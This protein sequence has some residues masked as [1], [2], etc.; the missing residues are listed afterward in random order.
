MIFDEVR[1]DGREKHG[2]DSGTSNG[3]S[4][5]KR[6]APKRHEVV[7]KE[8]ENSL[9]KIHCHN[10][11]GGAIHQSEANSHDY[12]DRYNNVPHRSGKV[13]TQASKELS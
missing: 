6:A 11:D 7:K 8:K 4:S 13:C 10:D 9:L 12:S 2:S 3:D 5:R 1:I